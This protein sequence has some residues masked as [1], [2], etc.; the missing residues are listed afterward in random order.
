VENISL[1]IDG[2]VITSPVG[3]SILEAAENHGIIIPRLCHH[4]NLKPF[5][6]CRL[7]LVEDEK[8]K[9]L[10]A[11]CVTPVGNG[12]VIQTN[13]ERITR[14]RRNIVRLMMAEHPESCVVCSKGN[15]CELR[16]SA[17]KL[18]VGEIGLYAMPNNQPLEQANPF[19]TRDLSKCILCGKCIRADHELVVTG[20]IDY[21]HRGFQSRPATAHN[22]GLEK[23]NCT[24]CGTCVSICPTGAL[25]P[26]R[27]TF[28]GTP[29]HEVTT[30]CGFCAVGCRLAMGSAGNSV[31]DVNPAVLPNSV[32]KATLCVRGH[33]AHDYLNTPRRLVGPKLRDDNKELKPVSWEAAIDHVA[34]RLKEIKKTSG[35]QSVAFLGSSKCTNEENY[36]FHKLA[37]G[38]L[39]T[40][41]IDNGGTIL[42]SSLFLKFDEKTD[43]RWRK[44]PLEKLEQSE[45]ILV[46]G[47]DASHSVPVVSY[48]LKRAAKKGIPLIVIDPRQTELS[49]FA[50]LWLPIQPDTDLDLINGLTA[51][52]HKGNSH[53]SAFIDRF[54]DG[55]SLFRYS[56]TSL[57]IDRVCQT[58]GIEKQ[59]LEQA[60][61][62]IKGKKV[63]IVLGSGVLQQRYREHTF[64][65]LFNLALMTGSVGSANAGFYIL[66]KENNQV[67]AMDMGAVP[68]HFPGRMSFQNAMS[69]EL[70]ETALKTKLS[71][72]PGLNMVRMVEEAEK[73]NLKALYIMG[74]NPLW[75]LPDPERVKNALGKLDLLVIQDII[76]GNTTSLADVILPGAAFSEK[77]GTFTNLEGRIQQL[78]PVV[79][80]PGHAK[81]DWEILNLL[82]AKISNAGPYDNLKKIRQEIVKWVPMYADL[83]KDKGGWVQDFKRADGTSSELIPFG[84]VVSTGN[85]VP[86]E[87]YPFTAIFGTK[88]YHAG[89]GTRT[90]AS[91]R[92]QDLSL[93][94]EMEIS[95][96]DA[97]DL[98]ITEEDMVLMVSPQ[99]E[100]ERKAKIVKGLAKGQILIPVGVFS[101]NAKT[102]LGLTDLSQEDTPGWN[103]CKVKLTKQSH[104]T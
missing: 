98:G 34:E 11:S 63:S 24:F 7:C 53:D 45:A 73:G 17:A 1:S 5:G 42:G 102:L 36:L 18:G 101:N 52:L 30:V 66:A 3:T 93:E 26:G 76:D 37:R 61:D 6:A 27:L 35:S 95:A 8:T 60:T 9:R 44:N 94:G 89:S 75:A 39:E 96:A 14:H 104:Q 67:G 90:G 97:L 21:T 71:P 70:W 64:M 15:R 41:N 38:A 103:T 62:L 86:K 28:V 82:I 32:N 16:L 4:P 49:R 72:D 80:P 10:M 84:A 88:R 2:E 99:G 22:V 74:E 25:S 33:F 79:P 54:T 46:V 65:S 55:F 12:M 83:L 58:T 59:I 78:T 51:L 81:P 19:I 23:S 92:I 85:N 69:R 77:A 20:A 48:Y 91:F 57:D 29:E 100:I 50:A 13:N 40:N 31:V 87:P 68:G 56:L 43:G 47:T